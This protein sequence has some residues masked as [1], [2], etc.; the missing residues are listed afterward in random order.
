MKKSLLAL[1]VLGAFAGA[2]QAQ[3]GVT[4]YGSFD[5]GVRHQTNVA[6]AGAPGTYDSNTT[7][8]SSGTYNS[9][10]FGFKGVEDLGGGLNAHFTLEGGFNSGTGVGNAGLF[11]RSAFVGLGGSWGSLDL[12]RQ[13]SINFKTIGK[14]D[15]FNYKYTGIVPLAGQGGLTRFNNDIQYS[16]KFGGVGVMAEY[17]LGEVAGSTSNGSTAA[18]GA[19]YSGGPFSVGAAYTAGK[20]VAPTAYEDMDNWTIGGAYTTGPF[21]IA[22]GYADHSQDLT[23]GGEDKVKDAW[24]G[25]SYAMSP[26]AALS[27]AYYQ[28]KAEAAAGAD[29]KRKLFIVGATYSLSKRTNF[30][31][32]VDNSR[33]DGSLAR[34]NNTGISVGINH[35]F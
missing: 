25:G 30:Y 33:Y 2:A 12:G 7:M 14:Y 23:A 24:V 21:R 8:G 1:A 19:S 9:N 6:V 5:A 27:V 34:P 15:P 31:A 3:T 11:D 18:V 28:T 35:L 32:D 26:A 4:V 29:G 10:R 22:V 20:R 13:Y 17:A 16:G